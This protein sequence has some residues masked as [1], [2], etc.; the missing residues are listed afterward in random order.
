M[1]ISNTIFGGNYNS[2]T[3]YGVEVLETLLRKWFS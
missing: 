2:V 1:T 3:E